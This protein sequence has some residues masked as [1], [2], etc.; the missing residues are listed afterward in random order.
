MPN[1]TYMKNKVVSRDTK[2]HYCCWCSNYNA[3]TRTCNKLHIQREIDDYCHHSFTKKNTYKRFNFAH[4]Y[5]KLNSERFTTTRGI[6]NLKKY[7]KGDIVEIF[8]NSR[9]FCYCQIFNISVKPIS[10]IP[11]RFLKMDGEYFGFKIKNHQEFVNLLNSFL[12][13][14]P[15]GIPEATIDSEKAIFFLQKIHLS[16]GK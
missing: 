10:K 7:Q 4:K 8:L 14:L 5:F 9:H 6:S 13:K 16:K 15:A 2:S 1:S 3:R 11:L 12:K